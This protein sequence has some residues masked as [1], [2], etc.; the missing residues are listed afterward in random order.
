VTVQDERRLALALAD[1]VLPAQEGER[2]PHIGQVVGVR[3]IAELAG[4]GGG[5]VLREV[6]MRR[7]A[8]VYGR[9]AGYARGVCG[10]AGEEVDE[11]F[12][13]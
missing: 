4:G 2:G 1:P 12:G 5:G 3:G 13:L 6:R 10:R 11:G 9:E 7:E 8:V